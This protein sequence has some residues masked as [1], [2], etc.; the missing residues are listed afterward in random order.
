MTFLRSAAVA[1]TIILGPVCASAQGTDEQQSA[2]MGDAFQFWGDFVPDA[3]KIEAC[4]RKNIRAIS[5]ACRA[6][7]TGGSKQHSAPQ[8]VADRHRPY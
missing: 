8:P 3:T 2:C 6:Q 1:A 5:P 7:F 4:L